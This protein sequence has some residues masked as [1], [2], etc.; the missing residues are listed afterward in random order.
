MPD[1]SWPPMEKRRVVG[2]SI[3]RLD[4]TAKASGKAKYASNIN[5]PGLLQAAMLTSPHAHAKVKTV[6]ISAAQKLPGVTAIRVISGPGT[7]IQWAGTEI[8][9]VA[10][11]HESIARD[12]VALIK[13]DYEVMPHVVREDN[14]SKV[15]NRAKPAGEQVTG[16][17]D[18]A[19]KA[20]DAVVENVYSIPVITHCCLEPHG[21]TVA[22]N[23]DKVNYWPSTQAV[24]TVG[25]D[26]ARGLEIPA[27]N[28]RTQMD[29]VGGGFGGKF[30]ADRWGIEAAQLS[31][32]SGGKPVKFFLDR[33][34]E[35]VVL[36]TPRSFEAGVDHGSEAAADQE[37]MRN[38]ARALEQSGLQP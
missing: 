16:D 1:Y 15:G 11:T 2:K 37:E 31:K 5:P 28:V 27:A 20:A 24:S 26:L 14:L 4:G 36:I 9:M 6:D 25:G 35:L 18:E 7:E 30:P 38:R 10:A 12:A 22:M 3:S 32:A 23:G 8:A 21:Q 33:E 17:P 29:Y 19:F 34:T 13:V